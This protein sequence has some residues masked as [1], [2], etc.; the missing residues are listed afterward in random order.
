M[1]MLLNVAYMY[2]LFNRDKIIFETKGHEIV[3]YSLIRQ[4]QVMLLTFVM[5]Q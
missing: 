1:V 5:Q 2:S 4:R 3:L